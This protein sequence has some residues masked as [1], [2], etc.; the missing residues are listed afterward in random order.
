M[1]YSFFRKLLAQ[2]EQFKQRV[3]EKPESQAHSAEDSIVYQF[4]YR[5]E[6]AKLKQTARVAEL[7]SRLHKLESVLGASS[8]KLSRLTTATNKG[9]CLSPLF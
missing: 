4:N 9:N 2:L 1:Y 5:P 6:Q 3:N 8:D 7:E